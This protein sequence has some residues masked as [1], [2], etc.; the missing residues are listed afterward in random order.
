[1]MTTSTGMY[2]DSF[3]FNSF[4][5]SPLF[6]Q[7]KVWL[8]DWTVYYWG[9]WIS[10]S[11]FVGIFIARVSKGRSIR[12]FIVAVLLVPSVIAIIWFNVFGTTGIQVAQQAETILSL[13]PETQLFA[14]FNELPLGAILS[15][16][17]L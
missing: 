16:I 4:D 10:W 2:L 5:V 9:W 15:F 7:K 12:E 6:E 8:A 13:P 3:L 14:I 11:P 17:A 1:M